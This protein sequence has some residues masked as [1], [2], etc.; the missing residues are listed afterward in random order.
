[1]EAQ[2]IRNARRRGSALIEASLITTLLLV[3]MLCIC[4]FGYMLF[5]QQTLLYQAR[6]A[7]RYGAVNSSD[8]T[9]V[10]NIVLYG[11]PGAPG[12]RRS[13]MFGLTADNVTVARNVTGTPEDRID[14]TVSNYDFTV[15]LPF[16]VGSF[17]GKPIRVSLP[18]EQ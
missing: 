16:L 11:Q 8:V 2:T 7:A 17:K 10:Q 3:I 13:G 4:D 12:D 18:V 5:Q 15:V 1:M 6:A 9:A 14:V